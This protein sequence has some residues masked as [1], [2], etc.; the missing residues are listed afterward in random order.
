MRETVMTQPTQ[1]IMP[2]PVN[3]TP[4]NLTPA[5]QVDTDLF[6]AIVDR[7]A[8]R[9]A[10]KHPIDRSTISVSEIAQSKIA[11]PWNPG[12]PESEAFFSN[13]I[14]SGSPLDAF[15]DTEIDQQA[16]GFFSQLDQLWDNSLAAV[17]ARKFATVPQ[18]VLRSIATNA[19]QLLNQGDQLVDQLAQCVQAALPQW[20]I[21]DL[22]VLS[23]PMAFAMRGEVTESPL[24]NRD[25]QTLSSTEQAKLSLTIARYAIDELNKTDMA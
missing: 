10:I 8:V 5:N 17:L 1:P 20:A 2:T 21:E 15:T 25:W 16:Q 12:L 11:Y 3:P 23:R 7:E 13:L 9:C 14:D 22:Q 24:L 18:D 4:A 6:N 19:T